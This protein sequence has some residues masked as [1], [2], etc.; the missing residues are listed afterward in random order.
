ML[1]L[2]RF[3][4]GVLKVE[5]FGVYPEKVLN[6][7]ARNGINVW[8]ARYKKQKIYCK[9]IARDFLLLHKIL[10]KS[11]IKVHILEKRG[12]PFFIRKYNKRFGIVLGLIIFF[13]FLQIMSGYIW[14]IDVV[15]NETVKESEIIS[16]CEEIGIKQG[17]RKSKISPKADA[18]ELL[19]KNDKLAWGSLNIEGCRLT[20]NVTEITEKD[21]DNSIATNLVATADGIVKHIDVKSGN[22]LVKVGDV[23][24]KGDV[25]VSGIIENMSETKFV[26]CRG[27][28]FAETQTEVILKENLTRKET[29]PN[30]KLKNKRA[31]EF[32]TLKIPL[33]LGAEKGLFETENSVWQLKLFG[34]NLPIKIHT[35]KFIFKTE[36]TV[37]ISP[38]KAEEKL[39]DRLKTEYKGSVKTQQITHTKEYA[40]LYAVMVDS[41]NIAKSENLIF[42]VGN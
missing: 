39:K 29:V 42:G 31:F 19:L 26:R 7:C 20:V 28:I 12:F 33:Y 5:F 40:Q 10:R 37:K 3:F 25:L 41:R 21:A 1:F 38:E 16:H 24:K 6:L 14:I 36:H 18:Q 8:S 35:K 4:C 23:V 13:S 22:C 2:Y 17:I 9:M 27:E 34:Q 15:G 11:G 30:G 32:F